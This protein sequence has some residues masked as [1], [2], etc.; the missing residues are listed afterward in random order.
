LTKAAARG[1]D[2]WNFQLEM[3]MTLRLDAS[4]ADFG[5][6][7]TALLSM[8][9]ESSP[10]VDHTVRKIIEDV[11]A[12]GDEALIDYSRQ[13]DRIDLAKTGIAVSAA[14]IA[15]AEARA[16]GSPRSISRW[17]ASP[18]FTSASAR[19]TCASPTKPASSS[20]GAGRRS[21][22]SGSMSRAARR[23]IPHRC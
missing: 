4:A 9:R 17:S 1:H 11:V 6:R 7:F 20:V 10:D 23:P 18:F 13:F 22:R 15:A 12:R 16:S 2:S 21:S 8:K 19:A 14:E 3:D 5:D